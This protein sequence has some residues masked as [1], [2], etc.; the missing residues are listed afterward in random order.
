MCPLC[1]FNH[2]YCCYV[3]KLHTATKPYN[4]GH[5]IWANLIPVSCKKGQVF[6]KLYIRQ[7]MKQMLGGRSQIDLLEFGL[8]QNYHHWNK[9]WLN[10]GHDHFC[11]S[12]GAQC[13]SN[14][15]LAN[16]TNLHFCWCSPS[17]SALKSRNVIPLY[18]LVKNRIPISSTMVVPTIWRGLLPP[19]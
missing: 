10:I 6:A 17:W 1:P 5:E 8:V 13:L 14:S 11:G 16:S 2:G 15:L 12:I 19:K 7:V 4:F 9:G 3:K 18:W